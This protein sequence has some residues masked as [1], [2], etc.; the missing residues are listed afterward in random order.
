LKFITITIPNKNY[1]L[2]SRG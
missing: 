2:L 1:T